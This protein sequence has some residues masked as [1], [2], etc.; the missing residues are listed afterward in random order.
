[1]AN[2]L[3][4]TVPHWFEAVVEERQLF[5]ELWSEYSAVHGKPWDPIRILQF[6]YLMKIA[7]AAPAGDYGEFG[8]HRGFMARVMHRLMDPA[9][10]LYSFDTFEGF[11]KADV[12]IEKQIY[13]N[14]W[15][16][17]NFMPTSPE[18]VAHYVGGGHWPS[19]FKTVKGWFPESFEGYENIKWRFVHIDFDLYQPI[20]SG[21]ELLW[22]R[23]VP[24]GVCVIHDYG[25]FGFPGA[26]KAVDEFFDDIGLTPMHLGDRWGS[27]GIV[28]P[29]R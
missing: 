28:K 1:M 14:D 6:M 9:H 15:H 3:M 10:T 29:K 5:D 24:G 19:N 13:A 25:C 2:Y 7:N 26:K 23:I 22:P 21:L 16:E 27:V 20:K 8:S 12:E 4:Q 17:G 18:T 11:T